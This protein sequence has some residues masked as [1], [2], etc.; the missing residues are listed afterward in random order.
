M[1]KVH[2]DLGERSYDILIGAGVLLKL[3]HLIKEM[4]FTGPVVVITDK[5]VL[6]GTKHITAPLFRQLKN[7]VT[8]IAVPGTE[9][10][11]SIKVFQETVQK[12]SAKTRTHRPM[13]VALG[14]GVVRAWFRG[15]SYLA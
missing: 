1:K 7:E 11:K 14:G 10:S 4:G 5:M 12:I 15:L 8:T 2:V 9:K 6:S 3:P 13:I